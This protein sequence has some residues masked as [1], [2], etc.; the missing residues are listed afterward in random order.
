[1][2][3][4]HPMEAHKLDS[5][6]I[7]ALGSS[8]DA[9]EGVQSFLQ[10]RPA[11]FTGRVSRDLPQP[12]PWWP[13]RTFAEAA[14]RAANTRATSKPARNPKPKAKAKPRKGK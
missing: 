4:D 8:P 14:P 12:Y 5:R 10:K 13:E 3:A 7:H 1:L 11:K 9:Y 2:G 6:M